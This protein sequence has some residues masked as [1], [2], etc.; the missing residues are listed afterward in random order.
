ML[1]FTIFKFFYGAFLL[2]VIALDAINF[3][4][5]S[6]EE[7]RSYLDF[8]SIR[9]K[10]SSCTLAKFLLLIYSFLFVR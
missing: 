1:H 3:K 10:I 4:C 5:Q 2:L 9:G 6:R 7:E 8:I